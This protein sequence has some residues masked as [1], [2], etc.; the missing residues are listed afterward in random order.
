MSDGP[1]QTE[2][3]ED[4]AAAVD[5]TLIDEMLRLSPVERLRQNDRMATLAQKLRAAFEP[6]AARWP[7]R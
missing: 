2:G 7:T 3:E 6:D 5:L 4:G 1:A